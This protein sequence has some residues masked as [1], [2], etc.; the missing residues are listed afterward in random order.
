M[1]ISSRK[2]FFILSLFIVLTNHC[3]GNDSPIILSENFNHIP[4]SAIWTFSINDQYNIP[5]KR[6]PNRLHVAKAPYLINE[7]SMCFYIP[8]LGDNYHDFRSEIAIK[9]IES[10]LQERWYSEKIFIPRT[11]KI[12]DDRDIVLQ[13]HSWHRE[14]G[15]IHNNPPLSIC[16]EKTSWNICQSYGDPITHKRVCGNLLGNVDFGNWTQ[17]VIHIKWSVDDKGIVQ[18]WK[19]NQLVFNK[20]GINT[21]FDHKYKTPYFKTGIYHP[22]WH[23]KKK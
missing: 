10:G 13:W 16:I 12:T 22:I 2:K 23:Q 8:H 11:W 15:Q 20:S 19:N 18:I 5:Y 3:L 4:S 9:S 6:Y 21:Y 17:W 14:H 1:G 7:N